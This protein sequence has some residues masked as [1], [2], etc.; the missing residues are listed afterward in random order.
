MGKEF[1]FKGVWHPNLYLPSGFVPI[2]NP[3]QKYGVLSDQKL[4]VTIKILTKGTMVMDGGNE[5]NND[6]HALTEIDHPSVL[7]PSRRM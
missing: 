2:A 5:V 7:S 3:T 4:P 6:V 1:T